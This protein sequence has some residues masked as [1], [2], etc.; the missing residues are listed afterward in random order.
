MK[1]YWFQTISILLNIVLLFFVG[2]LAGELK[3]VRIQVRNDM[4]ELTERMEEEISNGISRME[5]EL[6]ESAK[7]HTDYGLEPAGIDQKTQSLLAQAFVELK[8]WSGDTAL[9]LTVTQGDESWAVPMIHDGNGRFEAPLSLAVRRGD[10]RLAYAASSGGLI[11]R[12]DLGELGDISMLLPLQMNSWSWGEPVYEDGKLVLHRQSAGVHDKKGSS[13]PAQEPEFYVYLNGERVREA[14]AKQRDFDVYEYFVDEIMLEN[15]ALGDKV[16]VAFAC[17][18]EYGLHYEF[19]LYTWTVEE[20][21]SDNPTA[22]AAGGG[23][24]PKLSWE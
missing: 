22:A 24:I 20:T 14:A 16:T 8:E 17:R 10:I 9:T 3:N 15:A 2:N 13:V 1:K 12:E 19:T 23:N 5:N 21:D 4:D 18:D 6:K 11:T 7:L